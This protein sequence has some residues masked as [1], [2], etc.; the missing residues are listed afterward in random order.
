[1]ASI[2]SFDP[3]SVYCFIT[4][5][6]PF[7][8]GFLLFLK[9]FIFDEF[10]KIKLNLNSNY[11]LKIVIAFLMVVVVF[12]CIYEIIDLS[13]RTSFIL[14]MVFSDLM[15]LVSVNFEDYPNTPEISLPFLVISGLEKARNVMECFW[16]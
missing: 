6:S 10:L 12:Y 5:F 9:V 11:I 4:V 13:I 3:V 1:M 8:M 15:A 16:Y 7:L 14:L 2:N